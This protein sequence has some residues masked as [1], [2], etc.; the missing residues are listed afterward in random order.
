[1]ID[2]QSFADY[3][4]PETF[5]AIANIFYSVSLETGNNCGDLSIVQ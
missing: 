4:K 1:M 5:F 2:Y 3:V